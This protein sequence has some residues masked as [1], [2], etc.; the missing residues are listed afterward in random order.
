MISGRDIDQI[1]ISKKHEVVTASPNGAV[2]ALL[3]EERLWNGDADD[4]LS[5]TPLYLK[6]STAK[7]YVNKYAAMKNKD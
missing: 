5:L 4:A 6:E 3:A 7:A 1:N 2:I